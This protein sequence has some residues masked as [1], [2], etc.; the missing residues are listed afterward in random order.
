[1]CLG[2]CYRAARLYADLQPG[3]AR[4]CMLHLGRTMEWPVGTPALAPTVLGQV[5]SCRACKLQDVQVSVPGCP[6]GVTTCLLL[7][8]A[9]LLLKFVLP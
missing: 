1:M 8:A 4:G 6:H 3:S 2:A 9:A 5:T 7:Y